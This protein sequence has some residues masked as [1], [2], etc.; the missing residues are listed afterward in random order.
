M[1]LKVWR[2]IEII[3]A[4]HLRRRRDI[5]FLCRPIPW[6]LRHICRPSRHFP[7]HKFNRFL[8]SR[9]T[10]T[11]RAR[12]RQ[13]N[14]RENLRKRAREI[15]RALPIVHVG[16][17][18]RSSL[19]EQ[20]RSGLPGREGASARAST[21]AAGAAC[22]IIISSSI[23]AGINGSS[24][25]SRSAAEELRSSFG[26]FRKIYSEIGNHVDVELLSDGYIDTLSP[27][28][29]GHMMKL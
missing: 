19:A 13:E 14:S 21:P 9:R 15:V 1:M 10:T 26:W 23:S 16:E 29:F 20:R 7:F 12:S 11:P 27:L 5:D 18:V 4:L 6:H 24:F 28:R 17:C 25:S 3:I 22:S 2:T 8:S